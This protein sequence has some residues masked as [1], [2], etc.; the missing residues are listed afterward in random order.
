M[1][2]HKYKLA[3]L[4]ISLHLKVIQMTLQSNFTTTL[5]SE[6]RIRPALI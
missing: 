3:I 1:V 5:F 2:S 4:K 6:K